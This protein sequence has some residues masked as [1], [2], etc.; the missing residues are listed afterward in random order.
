M[1]RK[2]NEKSDNEEMNQ[3]SHEIKNEKKLSE[4]DNLTDE[5]KED[6]ERIKHGKP[7]IVKAEAYKTIILY[8]SRFANNA[9]PPP[10]WKEIYGILIGT[11]DDDFVYVESA[12]AL[13]YG[14][15]TDVQLDEKHYIFIDEIQQK[16]DKE[17]KGHYMVGWFHSHPGLNLF[18]SYIDLINQLAFQQNNPDFIGLVFD[19][20]LLGKKKEEKIGD[21][22][23]TKYDTGFEIYRITEINMSVND[24]KYDTNYQSV[25]YIVDGLNKF[26][27]ANLLSEISAL[28]TAGKPL[29]AAYG[30]EFEI[31]SKYKEP[32][33]VEREQEIKAKK[34]EDISESVLE[35][36]PLSED[37]L[38]DVDDFFYS[39]LDKKTKNVARLKEAAEQSIFEGNRAFKQKDAFMGVEKYREGIKKYDELKD[40][41]RELE[42]LKIVSEQ[43]ILS[44]HQKLAEEFSHE[45]FKL[46]KKHNNLF[47]K[48]EGNY[49]IGYNLLK[50]GEDKLLEIALKNI[51]QASIDYENAGDFAGAGVC[52]NKIGTIY[53]S[54]LNHPYNAALFYEQAIRSLN[55]AIIKGHPLRKALWSKPESLSK[56]ILEIKDIV[57]ELLSRIDN[58]KEKE[59]IIKELASI[60][61]N[62]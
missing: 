7:V 57:E 59:K 22:I 19:H 9:I 45:L 40:Y 58:P 46:A 44:N 36:I 23:L 5:I 49:L 56:K 8:V 47:Y 51:Q 12:E 20:T 38:F 41:E 28:V 48:A 27:F 17:K 25:D 16:L 39:D 31:E 53:Q 60:K 62:F 30:E 42:L 11:A 6:G 32:Q 55:N 34:M 15:S 13:T 21:N 52:Y 33:E 2:S 3:E 50:K 10:N 14:H 43:C 37:I 18:F 4:D 24:P 35:K 29:Q 1:H 26:F 61:F 54:R